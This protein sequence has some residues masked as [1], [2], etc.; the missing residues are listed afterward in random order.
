M[1]HFPCRESRHHCLPQRTTLYRA[2][3]GRLICG[4]W[5]RSE[6]AYPIN[7]PR[8]LR[9]GGDRSRKEEES[10]DEAEDGCVGLHEVLPG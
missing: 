5:T 9:V 3:F 6:K 7:L 1:P 10:E 8:L 2:V 4:R